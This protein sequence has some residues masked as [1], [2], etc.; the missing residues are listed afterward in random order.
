MAK[1]SVKKQK[2]KEDKKELYDPL[3]K[4]MGKVIKQMETVELDVP[5]YKIAWQDAIRHY[6][7]IP[8]NSCAYPTNIDEYT[9]TLPNS[10]EGNSK[11]K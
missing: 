9:G 10:P 1:E 2:A 7:Q 5:I 8:W 6:A 3:Y 4:I 11:W